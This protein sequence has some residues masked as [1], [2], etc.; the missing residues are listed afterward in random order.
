M[1][2][3]AAVAPL[4]SWS[5]GSCRPELVV[6]A[7]G[8]T[9]CTFMSF[10]QGLQL[11]IVQGVAPTAATFGPGLQLPSDKLLHGAVAAAP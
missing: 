6:A 8:I 5:L 1:Q 11:I 10:T 3:A 9:P 4:K 2:G 7:V